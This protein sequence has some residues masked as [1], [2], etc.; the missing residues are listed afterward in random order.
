[1]LASL[2]SVAEVVVPFVSHYRPLWM[3]LGVVSAYLA[4]ALWATNWLQHRIGYRWWRRL[5]YGTFAVYLGATPTASAAAATP[6]GRGAARST[7]SASRWSAD[8]WP[9][10]SRP[11]TA[12]PDP[13]VPRP[14]L[15]ER[16]RPPEPPQPRRTP[17]PWRPAPPPAGPL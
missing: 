6:A 8:S 15:A 14:L 7:C 1:L 16:R 11:A 3:G 13:P 10:A 9:S 4:A 12:P 17:P 5:H 2:F